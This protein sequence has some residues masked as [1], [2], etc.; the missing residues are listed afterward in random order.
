M[1]NNTNIS[2]LVTK[3]LTIPKRLTG[4]DLYDILNVDESDDALLLMDS[5]SPNLKG[6]YLIRPDDESIEFAFGLVR[7]EL[8][9]HMFII[10]RGQGHLNQKV[11]P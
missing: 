7:N 10:L 5:K 6:S 11:N 8:P 1:S 2:V 9:E 4:K 3:R